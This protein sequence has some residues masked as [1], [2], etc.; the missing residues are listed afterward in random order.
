MHL[1]MVMIIA[2]AG[3]GCENKPTSASE[4]P[5]L[6]DYQV[7]S[8][9]IPSFQESGYSADGSSNSFSPTPYP[10]IPSHLYTLN[11]QP[12]IVDWHAEMRSTLWSFVLGHD[13]DVSNVREIESSVYGVNYG[14]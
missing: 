2:L 5:A 3:L 7:V 6:P 8:P 13:P 12:R 11:T 14:H 10:E 9:P 1:S 4:P